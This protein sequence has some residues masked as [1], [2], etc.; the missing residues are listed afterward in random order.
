MTAFTCVPQLS[1][2]EYMDVIARP[3]VLLAVRADGDIEAYSMT[4]AESIASRALSGCRGMFGPQTEELLSWHGVAQLSTTGRLVGDGAYG[5]IAL[6]GDGTVQVLRQY[7]S[8]C[9]MRGWDGISGVAMDRQGGYAYAWGNDGILHVTDMNI[10]YDEWHLPVRGGVVSA[11]TLPWSHGFFHVIL[12]DTGTIE[13]TDRQEGPR[14]HG[15]DILGAMGALDDIVR[16]E[17]YGWYGLLGLTG[18]GRMVSTYDDDSDWRDY[19]DIIDFSVGDDDSCVAMLR[20]D[21]TVCVAG[22]DELAQRVSSWQGIKAVASGHGH[23]IGLRGDGT[24]VAAGPNRSVECEVSGWEGVRR[25]VT[26][27]TFPEYVVGITESGRVYMTTPHDDL[28]FGVVAWRRHDGRLVGTRGVTGRDFDSWDLLLAGSLREAVAQLSQVADISDVLLSSS[29]LVLLNGNGGVS[30]FGDDEGERLG[31]AGWR[32]V[33]SVC[34]DRSHV[35][36]LRDDGLVLATGD[37]DIA[38]E[39]MHWEGVAGIATGN[40]HLLALLGDGTVRA[41]GDDSC[42]QCRVSGWRGVVAVTA[43]SGCS[44]GICGD[45]TILVAGDARGFGQDLSG[46][47]DVIQL[48]VTDDRIV[49]LTGAGTTLVA[50]GD[51]G[52]RDEVGAWIDI[53]DVAITEGVTAGLTLD[54]T[55]IATA[56]GMEQSHDIE[57]VATAGNAIIGWQSRGHYEEHQVV[58]LSGDFCG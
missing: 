16:I 1:D 57:R 3:N 7:G 40:A 43:S 14:T 47:S 46:W 23:V 26:S 9:E 38:S 49:G 10:P 52:W 25:I 2:T 4:I 55:V 24:V 50:G 58:C 13:I 12:L 51:A 53:V 41:V 18:D 30:V 56:P 54:G 33:R 36:G 22:C 15:T 35:F 11:M 29:R 21:G 45:G 32:R 44:F 42:G 31:V 5:A 19:G 20:R 17:R 39:A 34:A 27:P 8:T 37:D 48:E 6:L 28:G